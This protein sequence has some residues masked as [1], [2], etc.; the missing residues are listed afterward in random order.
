MKKQGSSSHILVSHYMLDGIVFP[1]NWKC[2]TASLLRN[3]S[4]VNDLHD[5]NRIPKI[6]NTPPPMVVTEPAKC[7]EE[8]VYPSTRS[9]K[10]DHSTIPRDI[11]DY[12]IPGNMTTVCETGREPLLCC[13]G[14]CPKQRKT[15]L[16]HLILYC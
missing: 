4:R 12:L 6:L 14:D 9:V 2:F 5:H 16:H 1:P 3:G 11:T 8:P 10:C 13:L 7:V 15:F